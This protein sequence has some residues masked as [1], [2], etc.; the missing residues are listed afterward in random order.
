MEEG[1]HQWNLTHNFL[2]LQYLATSDNAP[3]EEH[4]A[5]GICIYCSLK[6]WEEN[7]YSRNASVRSQCH[8]RTRGA[9]ISSFKPGSG[10]VNFN[11][12]TLLSPLAPRPKARRIYNCYH[13]QVANGLLRGKRS[14]ACFYPTISER[15]LNPKV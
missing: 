11:Q 2:Y 14:Q 8:S 6:Q 15:Q 3:G 5:T 9:Y 13:S 1:D 10:T 4:V 7:A 12:T